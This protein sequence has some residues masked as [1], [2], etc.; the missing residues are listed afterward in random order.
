MSKEIKNIREL[1]EKTNKIDSKIFIIGHKEPDF[2]SIASA[3]GMQT[4]CTQLGKEAYIIVDDPDIILE[5]GFNEEQR[6]ETHYYAVYQRS[7]NEKLDQKIEK[8]S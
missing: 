2:D 4:L 7:K 8:T 1:Y 6:S 5:P 3:I